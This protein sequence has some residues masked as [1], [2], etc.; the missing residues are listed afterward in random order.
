VIDAS[1]GIDEVTDA[2]ARLVEN[3]FPPSES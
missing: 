1:A 3:R 2:V